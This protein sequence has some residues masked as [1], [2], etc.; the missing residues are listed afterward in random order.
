MVPE[1]SSR[2][3]NAVKHGGK[4]RLSAVRPRSALE[5]VSHGRRVD[6]LDALRAELE[7]LAGGVLS[8]WESLETATR[9]I[10][11]EANDVVFP[12]G[13]SHPYLY[14]VR[15]GMLRIGTFAPNGQMWIIGFSRPVSW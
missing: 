8:E 2:A 14:I 13:I 9:R 15:Q 11:L 1:A 7:A 10:D 4:D 6:P 12:V 3:M 5:G